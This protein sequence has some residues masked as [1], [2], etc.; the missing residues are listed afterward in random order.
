MRYLIDPESYTQMQQKNDHTPGCHVRPG[1]YLHH[2]YVG[3][4]KY[5]V[6]PAV[7]ECLAQ[8]KAKNDQEAILHL[9]LHQDQYDA[10]VKENKPPATVQG[11]R[12]LGDIPPSDLAAAEWKPATPPP[13]PNAPLT[14][15][16]LGL[17]EPFVNELV[18]RTLHYAG[19]QTAQEIAD[20]LR[21]PYGVLMSV[22][23]G[24]RK[25]Q[26]ID[27][28]GQ[29]GDRLGDAG[30]EYEIKP[31]KGSAALDDAMRKNTYV[32]PAPVPL[33]AYV[34]MVH[35][36][37][38][39]NIIVTQRT[40]HKAFED[41]VISPQ[42]YNEIGPAVNSAASIFL[43]GS[44]GNGK[45]SIA[46]RITRIMGDDIFIPYALEANGEIIKM[47]DP[48]VHNCTEVP[49]QENKPSTSSG[50]LPSTA[51]PVMLAALRREKAAAP[52]YDRRYI[53]IRRPTIVVGGEL[54][55]SMLDLQFNEYGKFYE[56]PMHMKANGG[57][58]MIDDFGRQQ[59]RPMDLLNR[60][61]VPLEKRYDYLTTVTGTKIEIPF[62]QLLIFST[63]LDPNQL[64]DEAFLRRIKYKIEIRD[65]SEPQ[66]R[67]IW[68]MVCKA[69]Q[70]AYD[71]R[72]VDYLIGKW[73]KPL[74]RP[75]RSCHPRDII[76]QMINIAKYRMER[77]ALN[78][79][80]IDAACSTYFVSAEKR[81]F[82]T[83]VRM[84]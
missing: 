26:L 37:T 12:C 9:Q 57:L 35:T 61:I 78:P 55:L 51:S 44:A 36:Q 45:T 20:R 42:V 62:D 6:A 31:P 69:R 8:A 56:A 58:F 17:P 75:F 32:G 24:M 46:E 22:F 50:L 19:R 27:I 2:M 13:A 52:G 5:I 64:V 53:R 41:L 81:D 49:E 4:I 15:A 84:D 30:M 34:E 60:W 38:V 80:L 21:V 71:N 28:V 54:T 25:L 14:F 72:A 66:Y 3:D 23:Q 63:N 70:V 10:V 47:Y 68:Q 77:T 40:I 74:N 29:R 11:R 79:D 43:F 65:P 39:R 59:V 73:Y 18:L 48:I 83:L 76:D 67:E 16:D 7:R 1:E 82:K 33:T